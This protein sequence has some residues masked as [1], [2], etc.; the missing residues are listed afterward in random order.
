MPSLPDTTIVNL[1][2]TSGSPLQIGRLEGHAW[3]VSEETQEATELEL[4]DEVHR[5]DTI[6]LAQDSMLEAGSLRLFGGEQGQTHTLLKDGCNKPNPSRA[7]VPRLLLQLAQIEEQIGALGED[8]LAVRPGPET[9]FERSA[10][11]D[12]ARC[13]LVYAAARELPE[14]VARSEGAVCLFINED[15]AFVA[16]SDL[17]VAKLRA[18]METLERPINPHMIEPALLEELL[19]RVYGLPLGKDEKN[20]FTR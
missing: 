12:F 15:T 3:K 2:R 14:S 11:T 6:A 17:S 19:E 8:P 10:S 7:D 9:E 13:N 1:H 4:G 16:M 5:G 18:V 20:Q